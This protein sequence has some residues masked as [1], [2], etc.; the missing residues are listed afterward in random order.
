VLAYNV[1]GRRAKQHR[2]ALDHFAGSFLH[3]VFNDGNQA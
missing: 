3:L 1:F 2:Q